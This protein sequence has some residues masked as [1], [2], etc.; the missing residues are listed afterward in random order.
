MKIAFVI[1]SLPV[2]GAETIATEYLIKLKEKGNDVCLVEFYRSGSFL[3]NRLA[4][5]NIRIITLTN[6]HKSFISRLYKK[7]LGEMIISRKF[8]KLIHEESFDILHIHT[9]MNHLN[10]IDFKPRKIFYSFHTS[11]ERNLNIFGSSHRKN[12]INYA[13]QGM[14]FFV[15]SKEMQR[16]AEEALPTKKIYVLPNGL[17]FEKIRNKTYNR[18]AFLTDHNIP[19][20]AFLLCHAA[21]MHPIKN[22]VKT[23][24]VFKEIVKKNRNSYLLLVGQEEK[25]ILS[26]INVLITE[27]GLKKHVRIMG[28]RADATAILSVCDAMILPSFTEGFPLVALEAQVLGVRCVVTGAVPDELICNDNCFKL[29]IHDSN[30]KWADYLLGSFEEKHSGRLDRFEINTV[31]DKLIRYY[32]NV[33]RD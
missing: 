19:Q 1:H 30:E 31:T 15:L 33:D 5:N 12:L 9:N 29:N 7:L 25:T 23:I 10:N 18:K 22:H 24:E 27:Y 17:D 2:G 28:N 16:A 8:N 4:D 26:E 13:K 14:N 21:R 3:Y 11:V 32:K 6:G 20:N